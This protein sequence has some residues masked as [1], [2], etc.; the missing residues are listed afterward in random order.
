[1]IHQLQNLRDQSAKLRRLSQPYFFP[2]T[3]DNGWQFFGLLVCLLFCVAGIVLFLVTGLMNGLTW[4]MPE[5][6]GQYFGGVQSSLAMIWSRGWGAGISALFLVGVVAFA[7]E[8][9]QLRYRRWL[10]WLFLGV[11]ILMLLCVNGVNAGITFI[12][13]DLTNALI[14]RDGE[15]SYR[16]LWVYGACFAVALPIRSLQ[17]YFTRKL[18]LFWR[19]WLS[20][21]L[22]DDYLQDRAY[23][24]LNP[25]DEQ[26]TNVDN[27][28]QRISEDVKDFTAQALEFAINIFDSILTFSLNILILYSVSESLTFAL[29]IYASA[30]S[31]L[32]IVAGRKLVRLN[33]FQLRYE[34][35]FRYGLV[36]IRDN[37]ESIAFYSGEQQESKEVT[38]RLATVVENFNLLIVW[39]V[40]LRVL[41]RSSIYAS[42]FIPYLILAAPILAGKM[43]YG[44]FAQANVAYNLVE[45]SLFFIVYNI[46]A[47]A[48]FSASVN[49]LEGFQSNVSNLDPEEWSDFVPKIVSSDR[50]ALRGVTVKTPRTDN[51]L[52]RDLSFSLDVAEGLLVVGPSG[53]GKT[54]LLRVVSGLWG[55]PTG[56]VESPGQGDLL[57][58]PQKPYMAL[59]SLREQLCYPLDQARFS[60]D[61]LRAVLD[62]VMLSKLMQRYPD[63]DIKQDWP[64]LLSLGEQQ[65]LAFAR[66][67]LNSPKV[68]VLDEATSALDV[69]TESRL[70]A[71]LRDREVSF[72]S[73]GHRPTLKAFHDTVL[74][75]SGTDEWRLIPAASYD[76]GRP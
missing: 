8:R 66:L 29:L 13:R 38:R 22:V 12:A 69:E 54:S 20:L 52:V 67:L 39:E 36:R 1:M 10:P 24:V 21:S 51:V 73:V 48:R 60:D 9:G 18:G 37:A 2:Y 47:L 75:L 25:N 42:N 3:E 65:R 14:A 6:T 62:Q 74:E 56:T 53:C 30:V 50:L 57:F 35:D 41:Q 33:N 19:E 40:L 76:F 15:A 59:G 49:R 63:L 34:A 64:R 46:E 7:S 26:A 43:D 55:S 27:P 17:F 71:L 68:V 31:I 70:Y 44:G 72:I 16:N 58:I 61:Q 5:L 45:N 11:I 28:D 32:M 4:L 23:Y